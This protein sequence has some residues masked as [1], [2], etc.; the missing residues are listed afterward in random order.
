MFGRPTIIAFAPA[1]SKYVYQKD[2]EFIV[3]WP[4][5]ELLGPTSLVAVY[6]PSHTRLRSFLTNAINQPEALRRIASLVQPN[7]VAEL[8]SWAQTGRVNAYKQVKKVT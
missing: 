1:V 2:D 5:V 7:I 4:S 3:G 6:G 8:Q